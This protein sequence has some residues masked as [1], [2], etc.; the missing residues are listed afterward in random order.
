M[1]KIGML[2][3][4]FA[5]INA[6]PENA[7]ITYAEGK[8]IGH[9]MNVGVAYNKNDAPLYA[10]NTIVENDNS[11]TGAEITLGVDDVADADQ[12]D[13]LGMEK[14]GETGS[15]VYEVTSE[16]APYVGIGFVE[17]RKKNGIVRFVANWFHKVQFAIPDEST[18]TKGEKLE[19]QCPTLKGK[20][21]GVYLDNTGKLRFRKSRNCATLAEANTWLNTQAHITAG[22]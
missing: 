18:T 4:V 20:V 7:A 9:A 21:M 3:P 22:E 10:D 13:L 11:V 15:E 2:R 16:S 14:T 12:V 5:K 17:V 1:P 8:V 19:W 6:E